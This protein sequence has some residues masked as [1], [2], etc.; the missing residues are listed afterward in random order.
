MF[1]TRAG[2]STFARPLGPAAIEDSDRVVA[3][4]PQRPPQTARVHAVVLVVGDHLGVRCDAEPAEQRRQRL[5]RRQGV[6]AVLSCARR[7]HVLAEADVD[8]AGNMRGTILI[9]PPGFVLELVSAVDDRP[10]L[11]EMRGQGAGRND[12]AK[13]HSAPSCPAFA[14]PQRKFSRAAI[15]SSSGGCVENIA[16]Q[17]RPPLIFIVASAACDVSTSSWLA[18]RR[19][20]AAIM[21]SRPASVAPP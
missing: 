8:G 15:R 9:V 17:L 2:W 19:R 5:N 16:A 3:E 6:S 10:G 18:W 13:R 14:G 11:T 21:R 20:R 4:I 12:R 7:S 1:F